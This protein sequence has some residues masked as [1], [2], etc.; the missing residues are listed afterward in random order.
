MIDKKGAEVKGKMDIVNE[1]RVN[2]TAAEQVDGARVE[3][4]GKVKEKQ[5]SIDCYR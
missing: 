1:N 5:K 2:F 4:E 3:V